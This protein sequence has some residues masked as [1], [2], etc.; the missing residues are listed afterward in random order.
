MSGVV[1]H[2]ESLSSTRLAYGNLG[3]LNRVEFEALGGEPGQTLT[4]AVGRAVFNVKCR[5]DVRPGTIQL[6]QFQRKV[7]NVAMTDDIRLSPVRP[8]PAL[9]VSNITLTVDLLTRGRP[10][11][12]I[13]LDSEKLVEAVSH[14][15]ANQMLKVNQEVCMEYEGTPL[16]L[17]VKQF[18]FVVG[19]ESSVGV[20]VTGGAGAFSSEFGL[21]VKGSGVTF[22]KAKDTALE[23]SGGTR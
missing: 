15:F 16:K 22:E 12:P 20:A 10:T 8:D 3:Y 13:K 1:V 11:A 23:L 14:E 19:P 17:T 5:D 6:G 18:S 21:F 4:L 7:A 2:A 9:S